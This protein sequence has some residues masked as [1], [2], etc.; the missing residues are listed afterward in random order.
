MQPESR[1][2]CEKRTENA[3][4]YPCAWL[5]P[6][7]VYTLLSTSG[8]RL[9]A[10]VRL[11]ARIR[12][13]RVSQ[14]PYFNRL[15]VDSKPATL[16]LFITQVHRLAKRARE[17]AQAFRYSR[18]TRQ[19]AYLYSGQIIGLALGF[20][21]SILNT[22]LLGP[23]KFGLY[24]ATFAAA[25]FITMFLNLG[26]FPSGAR[27]LALKREALTEQQRLTGGLIVLTLGMTLLGAVALWGAS[28]FVEQF[29]HAEIGRLLRWLSPL[30]TL[31]AL[32]T[33]VQHACWGTGRIER[34][35]V[36]N[37]TS[38]GLGLVFLGLAVFTKTYSLSMAIVASLL[39]SVLASAWALYGLHPRFDNLGPSLHEL[40]RDVKEF[41][42]KA[43]TGDVASSL[44]QRSDNLILLHFANVTAV[45]YYRLAGLII[46]PMT[47]FSRSL[48]A[49]FFSRFTKAGR[50]SPKLW[51]VNVAWLSLC[52]L[53]VLVLGSPVVHL[54][55]GPEYAAVASLLPL[56]ALAGVL[57]GVT[58]PMSR[59]LSAHGKGSYMRTIGI[60]LS[61]CTIVT[62]FAL[63][64]SFGVFGACYAAVITSTLNFLMASAYYR[65]TVNAIE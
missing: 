28:F 13:L 39:S 11:K 22:R 48:A 7:S 1:Q 64:P 46:T 15:L 60:T 3:Y 24:A 45:G 29:F 61:F 41:G 21:V 59:F 32:Q 34:L 12:D 6:N 8:T 14:P 42:F 10:E 20:G 62:S 19:A 56:I 58:L 65:K 27:L 63:I 44:G 37:I 36:F 16:D 51:M 35:S 47:T 38:K 25:E 43:F 49:T 4:N 50:I 54:I 2:N 18:A 57:G 40:W 55:F 31:L 23:T 52:F 17:Y 5:L 53:G 30:L 33:L 26:L 9:H